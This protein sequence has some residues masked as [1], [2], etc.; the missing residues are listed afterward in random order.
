M[1]RREAF[2]R[3]VLASGTVLLIPSALLSCSEDGTTDPGGNNGG[4]DLT[5]NM[6]D[7]SYSGL[8]NAGGFVV[9]SGVI[10]ANT[11][12]NNYVAL[13]S[14]CTHQGCTVGYSPGN[15]NFP[16]P[17]HGSVFTAN[18][19]VAVGP[20]T[21]PLKKYTVTKAGNILTIK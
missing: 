11:D 18:G 4:N 15:N 21:S 10:V 5:I 20:A 2:N 6:D 13:A 8:K 19:S 16:C 14:T 17:C 7:S 1:N 3:I 12:G 9:V